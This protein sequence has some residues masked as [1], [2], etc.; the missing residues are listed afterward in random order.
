MSCKG[1]LDTSKLD[2]LASVAQ[3]VSLSSPSL[4]ISTSP[5]P[6]KQGS[7]DPSSSSCS[8]PLSRTSSIFIPEN[9][10]P[11]LRASIDGSS[12]L[13]GGK[14]WTRNHYGRLERQTNGPS[15]RIPTVSLDEIMYCAPEELKRRYPLGYL[16]CCSPILNCVPSFKWD[17]SHNQ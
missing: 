11:H 10:G 2:I 7:T 15:T 13:M 16:I 9:M 14:P 12:P 1:T 17:D 5:M 6:T 3:C 4:T 8:M